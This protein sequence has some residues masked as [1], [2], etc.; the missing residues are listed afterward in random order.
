MQVILKPPLVTVLKH[1]CLIFHKLTVKWFSNN[2]QGLKSYSIK[3][4]GNDM[5]H[6]YEKCR[7]NVTCWV[8]VTCCENVT[9]HLKPFCSVN[10]C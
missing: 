5:T 6:F 2:T 9:C 10:Y 4:S 3:K 7:E 8:N 1:I